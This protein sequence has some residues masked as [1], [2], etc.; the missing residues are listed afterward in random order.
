MS[1]WT[2]HIEPEKPLQLAVNTDLLGVVQTSLMELFGPLQHRAVPSV[3]QRAR[4]L[5]TEIDMEILRAVTIAYDR[6]GLEAFLWPT[7]TQAAQPSLEHLLD[8]MA[9]TPASTIRAQVTAHVGTS[10]TERQRRW[11]DLPELTLARYVA[12][13]RHY[14][15]VVLRNLYPRFEAR[16]S[17]E[18][19]YL[20]D[21][22]D[23]GCVS[24]SI[25]GVHPQL[26]FDGGAFRFTPSTRVDTGTYEWSSATLLLAPMICSPR[27]TSV[28]GPSYTNDP[29]EVQM[30]R[31]QVARGH[32]P[33]PTCN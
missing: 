5:A 21:L 14:V 32:R 20:R 27:T 17:A 3:R 7:L 2:V 6:P 30:I 22:T 33:R 11:V 12:A 18:A 19:R 31:D 9:A 26:S 16:I 24:P 23:R 25:I 4:R 28:S 15:H 13:L 29:P 10:L 1:Q 8:E